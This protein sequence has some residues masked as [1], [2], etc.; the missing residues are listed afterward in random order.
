MANLGLIRSRGQRIA[1]WYFDFHGPDV[2]TVWRGDVCLFLLLTHVCP[3]WR[4]DVYLLLRGDVSPLVIIDPWRVRRG[5]RVHIRV[6]ST[7][8]WRQGARCMADDPCPIRTRRVFSVGRRP[9][10]RGL[11]SWRRG[12]SPG[13]LKIPSRLMLFSLSLHKY[14][15]ALAN[16]FI[17]DRKLVLRTLNRY[18]S[19][20]HTLNNVF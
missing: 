16:K 20:K 13:N 1:V 9:L 10:G 14:H 7:C 8:R 17:F 3:V 12:S 18:C 4:G 2:C 5:R 6:G 19:N 11:P 15:T